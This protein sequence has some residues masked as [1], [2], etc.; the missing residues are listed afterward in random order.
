[1]IGIYKITNLINGKVYIGQSIDI[2]RRWRSHRTSYQTEDKVLY[3]AMRKYGLENFSFEVIEECD[4]EMLSER[5]LYWIKKYD[6][7]NNGYNATLL[8][9]GGGHPVKLSEEQVDQIIFLLKNSELTQ[10][11]IAKNFNVGEDTISEINQG[12]TRLR[13]E[14]EYPIRKIIIGQN[15]ICPQCGG[16]KYK[17]SNLC[18]ECS[19]KSQQIGKPTRAELKELIRNKTFTEIGK[20]YGVSDNAVKKWCITRNLPSRKKDIKAYTDEEW[21]KI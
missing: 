4:R 13:T 1:M 15:K 9:V 8:T 5:E 7:Y 3:R 20:M 21:D 6:S 18:Q 2:I 16:K 17:T 14:I 10:R 11:Q 12:R 19:K